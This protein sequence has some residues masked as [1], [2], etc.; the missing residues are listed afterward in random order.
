MATMCVQILEKFG[1]LISVH[2]GLQAHAVPDRLVAEDFIVRHF[3]EHLPTTT[4][5]KVGQR[6]CKVCM[7]TEKRERKQRLVTTWC[8]ECGVAL[9]G[10]I[11]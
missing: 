10:C 3:L 7:N 1:T 9:C 8:K 11:F 4:N 2:K 6:H 5:R